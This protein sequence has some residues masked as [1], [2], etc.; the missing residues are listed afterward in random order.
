LMVLALAATP[1]APFKAHLDNEN[2]LKQQDT[3]NEGED[4]REP[5]IGDGELADDLPEFQRNRL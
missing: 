2:K 1:L 4:G 5:G 3:G